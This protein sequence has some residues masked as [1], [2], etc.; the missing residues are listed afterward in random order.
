[1]SKWFLALGL[2][3]SVGGLDNQLRGKQLILYHTAALGQ[4]ARLKLFLFPLTNLGMDHCLP[5]AYQLQS[6]PDPRPFRNGIVIGTDFSVGMTVSFEC[7]P[8]YSLIGEASLTCLHGISR[9]WN[10]PLPRCEGDSDGLN[11]IICLECILQDF[12]CGSWYFIYLNQRGTCPV[13]LVCSA[14]TKYSISPRQ[15][16]C[17]CQRHKGIEIYM[18]TAKPFFLTKKEFFWK[19]ISPQS[20]WEHPSSSV[21][22]SLLFVNSAN[23][24]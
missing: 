6:C 19:Y 15:T 13:L 14:H 16:Y 7:L 24:G 21:L 5:P 11:L 22:G 1:M 3:A 17:T 2:V 10:H 18:Y 9:N 4:Q 23:G 20:P 12:F 8:G